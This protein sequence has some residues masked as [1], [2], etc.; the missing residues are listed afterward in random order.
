MRRGVVEASLL[1]LFA[2][3]LLGG[4]IATAGRRSG[5][6]RAVDRLQ[7]RAAAA[8]ALE[9]R[10]AEAWWELKRAIPRRSRSVPGVRDTA[11]EAWRSQVLGALAETRATVGAHEPVPLAAGAA[12]VAVAS[13]DGLTGLVALRA[14][15]G[16][17]TLEHRR[18]YRVT[19]TR[20]PGGD[21]LGT[22][23]LLPGL[24]GVVVGE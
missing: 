15:E 9:S 2:A 24:E 14:S 13:V 20:M 3:L 8:A 18:R 11:G 21:T 23:H 19:R 22:V 10:L 12:T 4:V 5:A 7:H 17:L 6:V 1:L 16:S